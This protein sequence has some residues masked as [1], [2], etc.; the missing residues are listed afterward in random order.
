[1]SWNRSSQYFSNVIPGELALAGATRN[2]EI[3]GKEMTA[4]LTFYQSGSNRQK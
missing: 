1:V 2:P 3:D 4:V